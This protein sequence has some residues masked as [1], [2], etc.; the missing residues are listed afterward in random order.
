MKRKERYPSVIIQTFFFNVKN[1]E[2][3]VEILKKG[4]PTKISPKAEDELLFQ[5]MLHQYSKDCLEQKNANLTIQNSPSRLITQ[6][7]YPLEYQASI[8]AQESFEK[9]K[10]IKTE[11]DVAS[12]QLTKPTSS[13]IESEI[14]YETFLPVLLDGKVKI[15]KYKLLLE[16]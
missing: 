11:N 2:S 12:T 3:F 15:R 8:H 4:L 7:S 1:E 16:S 9:N 13:L 5:D 6:T 10:K 14:F